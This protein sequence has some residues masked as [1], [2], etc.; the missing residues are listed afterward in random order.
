M[1]VEQV[2][3]KEKIDVV[4]CQWGAPVLPLIAIIRNEFPNLPIIHDII[5]YPTSINSI[6]V[7]FQNFFYGMI[8]KKINGRIHC[9][10]QMYNY[11]AYRF[12]LEQ[13]GKDLFF[14]LYFS[15]SF[16]FQKRLPLLSARDK[17]PHIIFIGRADFSNKRPCDDVRRQIREITESKI[18][19]WLSSKN[20]NIEKNGYIHFYPWFNLS[21]VMTGSMATFMTQFDACIYLHNLKKNYAM[22]ENSLQTRFRFAL[23]AGIPI[24]MPDGYYGA[25]QD[26]IEKNRIGFAYK[27]VRELKAKLSDRE[28]MAEYRKNA[29]K[30]SPEFTFENNF[31]KLDKFIKEVIYSGSHAV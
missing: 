10:Q 3:M 8:I 17:E 21:E 15:S 28:L 29:V 13:Q 9:S 20:R 27:D 7:A 18:H 22:Y 12:N 16:F 31:E 1:Q 23:T 2:I 24:V 5:A 25:C 11:L 30:A 14:P 19:F 26:I 4:W 6:E